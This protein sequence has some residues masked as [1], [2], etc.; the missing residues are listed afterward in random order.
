MKRKHADYRGHKR[1]FASPENRNKKNCQQQRH[2]HC[3]VIDVLPKHH[4]EHRDSRDAQQGKEIA[5]GFA[6]RDASCHRFPELQTEY[7]TV[8]LGNETAMD[9]LVDVRKLSLTLSRIL[10]TIL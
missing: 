6:F 8:W 10:T 4:A 7:G 3:G 5:D 9:S 2:S 1:W